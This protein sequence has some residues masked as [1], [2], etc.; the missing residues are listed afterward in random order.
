M[1]IKSYP[2]QT[3]TVHQKRIDGIGTQTFAIAGLM[4]QRVH[5][6][7]PIGIYEMHPIAIRPYIKHILAIAG[8]GRDNVTAHFHIMLKRSGTGIKRNYALVRRTQIDGRA[9]TSDVAESAH[10]LTVSQH[11]MISLHFPVGQAQR[12]QPVLSSH[13]QHTLFVQGKPGDTVRSRKYIFIQ[14]DLL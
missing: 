12:V 2:G 8:E 10:M 1:L 3:I 14:Q 5:H 9:Y 11:I 7:P 4:P 6:L 13:P